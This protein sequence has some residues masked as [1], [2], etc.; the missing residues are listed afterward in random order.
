[1]YLKLRS[2]GEILS[3]VIEKAL[4]KS[5]FFDYSREANEQ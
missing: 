3:S 5:N 2:D 1:M 4:C